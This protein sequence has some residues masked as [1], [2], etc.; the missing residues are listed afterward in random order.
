MPPPAASR[1]NSEV[2]MWSSRT[3]VFLICY[4]VAPTP[5]LALRK[6]Q[7]LGLDADFDRSRCSRGAAGSGILQLEKAVN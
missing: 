5:A 1:T 3:E 6:R 4:I 2:R 7:L